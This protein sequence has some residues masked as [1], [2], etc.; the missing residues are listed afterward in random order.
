MTGVD[1][2]RLALDSHPHATAAALRDSFVDAHSLSVP[3]LLWRVPNRHLR[4]A[5]TRWWL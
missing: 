3:D 1:A 4:V 5:P 2:L